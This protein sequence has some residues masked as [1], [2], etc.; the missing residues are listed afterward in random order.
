MITAT[1]NLSNTIRIMA[2]TWKL[3]YPRYPIKELGNNDFKAGLLDSLKKGN[4]QSATFQINGAEQKQYIE[5]NPLFKTINIYDGSMQKV[6]NRLSVKEQ[7]S[8]DESK[9]VKQESMKETQT[10]AEDDGLG[11]QKKAS[12]KRKRKQSNSIT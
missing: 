7:K 3:Y 11:I 4:L 9:S 1:L 10:S 8:E 5:A 2:M 12:K 6:D